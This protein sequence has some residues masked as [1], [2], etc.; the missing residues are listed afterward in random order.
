MAGTSETKQ[1][2]DGTG[3]AGQG[4]SGAALANAIAAATGTRRRT[5]PLDP[6]I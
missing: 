3:E 2:A 6:F 5:M 1:Q 4:P